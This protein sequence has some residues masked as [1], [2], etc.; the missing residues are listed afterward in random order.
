MLPR[1]RTSQCVLLLRLA[2]A[3]RA[4][5]QT[6]L[7]QAIQQDPGFAF[8]RRCV[9]V[10]GASYVEALNGTTSVQTLFA[11]PDE[12][13]EQG[14]D[15]CSTPAAAASFVS[16]LA[17]SA[18]GSFPYIGKEYP[19][20]AGTSAWYYGVTMT[21]DV[22]EGLYAPI[23]NINNANITEIRAVGAK[24]TIYVIDRP[25]QAPVGTIWDTLVASP[26]FT[27][28]VAALNATESGGLRDMLDGTTVP[29]SAL[30]LFAPDDSAYESLLGSSG[31]TQSAA[32]VEVLYRYHTLAQGQYPRSLNGRHFSQQLFPV[33]AGKVLTR[34]VYAGFYAQH[35]TGLQMPSLAVPPLSISKIAPGQLS[36]QDAHI[37][38][39]DIAATNGVI[40]RISALL[41][42]PPTVLE[43]ALCGTAPPEPLAYAGTFAAFGELVAL[44]GDVVNVTLSAGDTPLTVFMPTDAAF[45]AAIAAGHL[46]PRPFGQS[47]TTSEAADLVLYHT[48]MT[49]TGPTLFRPTADS[50]FASDFTD[51]QPIA[52]AHTVAG[53]AL[54]LWVH[55]SQLN[56]THVGAAG[57]D[58]DQE[59]FLNNAR[60]YQCAVAGGTGHSCAVPPAGSVP[61]SNAYALNEGTLCALHAIDAVLLPPP[62]NATGVEQRIVSMNDTG[63]FAEL[64]RSVG[65]LAA[66]GHGPWTVF[67]PSN[68]ALSTSRVEMPWLYESAELAAEVVAYHVAPA[69]VYFSR[70]LNESQ[71]IF[72]AAL[73]SSAPVLASA[74]CDTSYCA[75]GS[76]R[77]VTINGQ[78]ATATD[79]TAADGVLHVLEGVL[80][81]NLEQIATGWGF[82]Q[83]LQQLAQA[84]LTS[85][86]QQQDP[87][88]L[89]LVEGGSYA[90]NVTATCAAAA[91]TAATSAAAAGADGTAATRT[92][93]SAFADTLRYHILPGNPCVSCD[94]HYETLLE[95][96]T[97]VYAYSAAENLG[98]PFVA[99]R[100]GIYLHASELVSAQPLK[101]INGRAWVLDKPLVVPAPT[102]MDLLRA[103]DSGASMWAEWVSS[104]E[105]LAAMLADPEKGSYTM[106]A[107]ADSAML[108]IPERR[109]LAIQHDRQLAQLL[110]FHLSPGWHMSH[111]LSNA[112]ESER[113]QL[114][115]ERYCSGA[116]LQTQRTDC[117]LH[118]QVGEGGLLF[119]GTPGWPFSADVITRDLV[120]SNGVLHMI[121][122]VLTYDGY[123][124]PA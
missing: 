108:A 16:Y 73:N 37:T 110:R 47:M 54:Q 84:G 115:G 52:S 79:V 74:V 32:A 12:V 48:A 1:V 41:H 57:S 58:F 61:P 2:L 7:W 113:Q 45:D 85:V 17:S 46:P 3:G 28:L 65:G 20:L 4:A 27:R 67:A 124:L 111:M 97:P 100:T 36:V 94:G 55:L 90:A 39:P 93:A 53:Q 122:S 75:A 60:L 43:L 6:T 64:L 121:S 103:S 120:A 15:Q 107:P 68:A 106:F 35:F 49:E 87:L 63:I 102:I 119:M 123:R 31:A 24:Y 42:P 99:S 62:R 98:N 82:S 19:T 78:L 5:A 40:H 104:D 33:P 69:Q 101:A 109:R 83:G 112:T 71:C 25:L 9:E 51:A 89:L 38:Q 56:S 80:I 105:E 81:P 66:F 11:P 77:T 117:E 96:S 26:H 114:A 23:Q 34:D 13:L 50:P 18:A 10:A 8:L 92:S 118:T 21:A 88:A 30:T 72:T 22:P 76:G 14:L 70:Y 44:A 95:G 29:A 59:V 91:S 86:L 116:T